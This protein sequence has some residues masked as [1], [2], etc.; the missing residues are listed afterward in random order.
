MC[1]GVSSVLH[2]RDVEYT[3]IEDAPHLTDALHELRPDDALAE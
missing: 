1:W 3:L 2:V